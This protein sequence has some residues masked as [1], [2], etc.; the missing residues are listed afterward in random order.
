MNAAFNLSEFRT[1]NAQMGTTISVGIVD[2]RVSE[3]SLDAKGI[4]FAQ[5]NESIDFLKEHDHIF[6][7]NMA[8]ERFKWFQNK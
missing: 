7:M 2:S 5:Y 4:S 8:R 1:V 3:N 6:G